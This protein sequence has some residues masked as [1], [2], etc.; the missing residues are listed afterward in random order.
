MTDRT[1]RTKPRKFVIGKQV[2]CTSAASSAYRVG[3]TYDVVKH[4][5]TEG[6]AI[7]ARDGFLDLPSLVLSTFEPVGGT[8]DQAP[9]AV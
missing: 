8:N 3:E 5:Q 9:P 6:A 2:V 4:P 1:K 7:K